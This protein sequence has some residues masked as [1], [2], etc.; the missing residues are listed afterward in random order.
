[1]QATSEADIFQNEVT[2]PVWCDYK[3]VV[4]LEILQHN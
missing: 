1:V 3:R 2:L 4:Y